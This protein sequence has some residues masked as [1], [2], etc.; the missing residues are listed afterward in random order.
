[1]PLSLTPKRGHPLRWLPRHGAPVCIVEWLSQRTITGLARLPIYTAVI[2]TAIIV[3]QTAHPFG[4]G[5]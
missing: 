1:M 3:I 4:L 5:R 2:V